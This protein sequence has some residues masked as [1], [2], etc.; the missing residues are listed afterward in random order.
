MLHDWNSPFTEPAPLAVRSGHG[1]ARCDRSPHTLGP[2]VVRALPDLQ[3]Q[4][5]RPAGR[6]APRSRRRSV[7]RPLH[8]RRADGRG[9]RLPGGAARGRGP[10]AAAGRVGPAL[11]RSV[12]HPHGRVPRVR[13]VRGAEPAARVA[14]RRR[15][16]RG[17]GGRLSP[18]HVRPHRP[19]AAA[20]AAVRLRA[21]RGVAGGARRRRP[22]RVLVE[23]AR[24]IP[25]SGG[26]PAA[27][28]QQRCRRPGQRQ[29][30]RHSDRR[31]GRAVRR[32]ARRPCGGIGRRRADPLDE[33]HRP[34]DAPAVAGPGGDRSQ[35][36][37]GRLPARGHL[38]APLSERGSGR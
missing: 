11:G 23:G 13:R 28:L 6:A 19:D 7:L 8:A 20:A 14:T 29:G 10:A 35:P 9:R 1:P 3:G 4:A 25:G 32:A 26:V 17:D 31:M 37:P 18:R 21:R 27:G 22:H 5:R 34:P 2:G 33:R 36:D 24:R 30:A 15:L 16:R 38:A 12:V